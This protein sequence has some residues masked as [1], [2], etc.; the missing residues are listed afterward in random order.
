MSL[1][2]AKEKAKKFYEDYADELCKKNNVG[3]MFFET[4]ESDE[5]ISKLTHAYCAY[6]LDSDYVKKCE[7]NLKDVINQYFFYI[8]SLI[9]SN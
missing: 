9:R 6:P 4:D 8:L 2:E 5:A 7:R 3:P 1:D